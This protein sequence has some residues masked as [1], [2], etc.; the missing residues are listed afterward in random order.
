MTT[1]T[2]RDDKGKEGPVKL[3]CNSMSWL[4]EGGEAAPHTTK[5]KETGKRNPSIC[6]SKHIRTGG[7]KADGEC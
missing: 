5:S 2:L 4:L 1:H 7:G 6:I 3:V